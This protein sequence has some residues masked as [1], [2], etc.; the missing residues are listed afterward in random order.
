MELQT[1]S[2][3][4]SILDVLRFVVNKEGY[5]GLYK[6]LWPM[7]VA[8]GIS[9]FVFFFWKVALTAAIQIMRSPNTRNDDLGDVINL[10]VASVAGTINVLVTTPLWVVGTRLMVQRRS[11][12]KEGEEGFDGV[13]IRV[14]TNSF[15]S[16]NNNYLTNTPRCSTPS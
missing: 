11:G 9:N 5:S 16:P 14:V 12:K 10:I 6:G 13:R 7:L 2:R 1:T 3:T 4:G 8:L 15:N